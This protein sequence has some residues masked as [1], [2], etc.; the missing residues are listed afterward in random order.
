MKVI[1]FSELFHPE[2][3]STGWYLTRI[4]EGMAGKHTTEAVCGLPNYHYKHVAVSLRERWRGIDIKRCWAPRP[5]KDILPLR[6]LAAVMLCISIFLRGLRTCRPGDLIMVVSNPPF[7]PVC[8]ALIARLRKTRVIVMVHDVYPDA[9]VASGILKR[10]HWLTRLVD[11]ILLI[12]LLQ[13]EVVVSVGRDMTELLVG[14]GVPRDKIVMIRHWADLEEVYPLSRSEC[15]LIQEL[16]LQDRFIVQCS[17]NMG[18]THDARTILDAAEHLKAHPRIHF[19]VS[20]HGASSRFVKEAIRERGLNNVTLLPFVARERLRE[21]VNTSDA[22]VISLNQAMKGVSV[23]CR[24]YNM[25]GAGRPVIALSEPGSEVALMVTEGDAGTVVP[26]GDS[27]ALADA[28]VQLESNPALQ[29]RQ[30]ENARRTVEQEYRYE[31]VIE[32]YEELIARLTSNRAR[33]Q[34][35]L[36]SVV[37][38]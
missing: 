34:E 15:P 25:M 29:Q 38:N 32:T 35:G 23:P 28:I 20:A 1:I 12:P 11:R 7:L 18:R 17:G 22:F 2:V 26:P 37:L 14:K 31:T 9:I 30:G 33:G 24:I 21:T 6:F 13:A 36:H 8:T 4:A 27:R 5:N 19:L 3:T 16:G 10:S